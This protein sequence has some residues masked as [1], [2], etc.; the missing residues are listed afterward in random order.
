MITARGKTFIKRYLAGQ[1]GQVV[2]AMSIG[3]GSQDASINDEKMQFEF[4]RVPVQVT[5]YDFVNDRLVF[6]GTIP[7]EVQGVV[8]EVGLWTSDINSAAGNS[9]S[10][11]LTTFDSVTEEWTVETFDS[12][13]TRIGADSLKHTPAASASSTSTLIG[14][15]MDLSGFSAADTFVFAYNVDNANTSTIKFRFMTDASNYYEFVITSPTAGYKIT[16]FTKG[17]AAVV[18]TPAWND[19]TQL[20]VVTTATSGGAASVVFDGVRIDDVDT[21][22]TDY[23]LIARFIPAAPVVKAL[24]RAQDFEYSLAVTV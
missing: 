16:S 21:L 20:S 10:R 15:T 17:S 5:A 24:G 3:I 14:L 2:G 19:V 7:E 18:G 8:Y 11:I 4:A 9:G 12:L 13:V 6:K 1:S 23:G 22:S